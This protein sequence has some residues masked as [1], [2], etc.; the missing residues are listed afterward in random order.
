MII[1]RDVFQAKYGKS[2]EL[3]A[4]F[5]EAAVKWSVKYTPRVLTDASG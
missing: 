3:V 4:L 5:K 2:S 1:V